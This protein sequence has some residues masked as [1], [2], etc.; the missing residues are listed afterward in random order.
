MSNAVWQ[1]LTLWECMPKKINNEIHLGSVHS[2]KKNLR[3][4]LG[5][6]DYFHLSANLSSAI[7]LNDIISSL[8][9]TQISKPTF[10]CKKYLQHPPPISYKVKKKKS[11]KLSD[12]LSRDPVSTEAYATEV[13]R[14]MCSLQASR[15]TSV[16]R[17]WSTPWRESLG[18]GRSAWAGREPADAPSGRWCGWPDLGTNLWSRSQCNSISLTMLI[19]SLSFT[20]II[21]VSSLLSPLPSIFFCLFKSWAQCSVDSPNLLSDH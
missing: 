2:L 6:R 1:G 16:S 18:W 7:S 8:S 3:N 20:L 13:T 5:N 4:L 11:M 9:V 12:D 15:W 19:Q 10:I 21:W 17:T 14:S